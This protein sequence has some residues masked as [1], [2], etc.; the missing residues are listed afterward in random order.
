MARQPQLFVEGPDDVYAIV[1][2][3]VKHEVFEKGLEV[4]D[5]KVLLVRRKSDSD[6]LKTAAKEAMLRS[7]LPTGFVLDIDADLSDRWRELSRKI[8]VPLGIDPPAQCPP[9]GF[10]DRSPMT[11]NK[12]GVWLMP[13]NKTAPGTLENLLLDLA[14]TQSEL[15]KFASSCTDEATSHEGKYPPQSILKARLHCW[16]AWQDKP[17]E[18]YGKAIEFKYLGHESPRV[19]SFVAWFCQLYGIEIP[20]TTSST[21]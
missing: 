8:L 15:W 12:I 13:D 21:C 9:E 16:L 19:Q 2:L 6:L 20:R 14:P 10:I 3:L 5:Q 7:D 17:G 11:N 18:P 4:K 1:N